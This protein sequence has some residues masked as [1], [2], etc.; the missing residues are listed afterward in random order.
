MLILT[1][2]V[3]ESIVIKTPVGDVIIKILEK[4]SAKNCKLGITAS[5]EIKVWR[6]ELLTKLD[7]IKTEDK[8]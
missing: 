1:R 2:K 6:G 3:N 8:L 5:Q 4:N 7:S